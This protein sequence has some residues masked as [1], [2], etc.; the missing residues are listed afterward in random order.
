M[1]KQISRRRLIQF[2]HDIGAERF[3]DIICDLRDENI[4][5]QIVDAMNFHEKDGGEWY[6]P[7]VLRD[8]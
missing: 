4:Q 3:A 1:A 6:N 7:D 5:D 2:V 8:D